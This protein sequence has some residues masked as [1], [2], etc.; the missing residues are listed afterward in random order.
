MAELSLR[1]YLQG[2]QSADQ[3]KFENC[4]TVAYEFMSQAFTLYEEEISDSK[5]QLAAITL[6]VAT[7]ETMSCFGEENHDPLRSQCAVTASKLLK[8][9]DQC[10]GVAVSSHLFWSG[11][12]R[13]RP[14]EET[15]DGKRVMDCLK[16][17]LRIAN[18][19]MDSSAQV[20]LFVEVLNRYLFYYEK[21]CDEV[22]TA[23]LKQLIDKIREDMSG[24]E[25][26]EETEQINKHF[27]TT[28]IHIRHKQEAGDPSGRDYAGLVL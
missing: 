5:A 20:Q 16:K 11:R 24:L 26:N 28:L 6:I 1:L 2:A 8:K 19:C 12:T 10:R 4:E 25:A 14:E 13:E 7:F 27:Q 15:L 23:V 21:G 18:Q 17:S 3:I 22:T 9:P